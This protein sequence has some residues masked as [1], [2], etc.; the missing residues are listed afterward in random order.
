[1]SRAWQRRRFPSAICVSDTLLGRSGKH[2]GNP[3]DPSQAH[4][5]VSSF[6]CTARLLNK[7]R[8][9]KPSDSP[10]LLATRA[11]SNRLLVGSAMLPLPTRV[12]RLHD[13]SISTQDA[14]EVRTP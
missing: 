4:S 6:C 9:L 5:I 14:R 7:G 13:D 1:M 11:S 8:E 12:P 3:A 10:T 2:R